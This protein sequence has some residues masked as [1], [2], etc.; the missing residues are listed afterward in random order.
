MRAPSRTSDDDR[1]DAAPPE[2]KKGARADRSRAV[3]GDH[4][5]RLHRAA[6]RGV[7]GD[8]Q[9]LDQCALQRRDTGRQRMRHAALHHGVLGETAG[10]VVALDRKLRTVVVLPETA[11]QAV[12]AGLHRLDRDESADLEIVDARAERDD[13]ATQLVTHDDGVLHAGERVRGAARGHGAV[14]I[15]EQVAAADAVVAHPQLHLTRPGLG[16]RHLHEPQV[17]PAEVERGAHR[18]PASTLGRAAA[19]QHHLRILRL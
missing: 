15:L 12:T 14:E 9:R 7:P 18:W 1:L 5:S 19:R 8:R 13:L 10:A 4:L 16:L 2:R 11:V 3:N 17:L 6:I